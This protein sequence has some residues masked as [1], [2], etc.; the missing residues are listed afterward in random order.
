MRLNCNGSSP[1]P[2]QAQPQEIANYLQK[3]SPYLTAGERA[4]LEERQKRLA[5]A[6]TDTCQLTTLVRSTILPYD[7]IQ[8]GS[9]ARVFWGLRVKIK[10]KNLRSG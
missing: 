8:N 7:P 6:A 9:N 10:W 1:Q 2:A 4:Q 3:A 5:L